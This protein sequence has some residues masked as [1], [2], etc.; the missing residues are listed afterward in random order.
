MKMN[1]TRDI[2]SWRKLGGKWSDLKCARKMVCWSD[3]G[4]IAIDD[5]R[6]KT[7]EHDRERSLAVD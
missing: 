6:N 1:G 7:R 3:D 5:R 2:E 4:P